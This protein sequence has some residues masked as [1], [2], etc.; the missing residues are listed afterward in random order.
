MK[1]VRN[2]TA[3]TEIQELILSSSVD[4]S[5]KEIKDVTKGLCDRITIYRVLER[6]VE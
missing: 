1:S 4:L 3:K 6:L 2:T 5:H